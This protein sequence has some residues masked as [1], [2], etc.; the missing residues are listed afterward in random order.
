M[1]M[2]PMAMMNTMLMSY[3]ERWAIY[4]IVGA[5]RD[6]VLLGSSVQLS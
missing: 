2:M 4:R 6:D 3:D 5:D 1:V